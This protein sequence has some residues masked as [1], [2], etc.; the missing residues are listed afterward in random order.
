MNIYY[1]INEVPH[2]ENTILTVGTFDGVHLGHQKIIN[3]VLFR[4]V[5]NA[6]RNLL[7]TFEPHPHIVLRNSQ[8]VKLITTLDEKINY[9]R[10]HALQNLLVINFTKQFSQIGFKEFVKDFLVDKI[11]LSEIVIGYDHQ[12]GKN[13]E[14][15][16]KILTE[17][18]KEFDFRVTQVS[19]YSINDVVVSSSKIRR[20][21]ITGDIQRANSFLGKRFELSG[22]VFK[23]IRRGKEIG[24]PTANIGLNNRHKIIPKTG[25]YFVE[26]KL[27]E[28]NYFGMMNIGY[29]PTFNSASELTLEVHIFYFNEN[30]YEKDIS[31]RFIDR[32][33]DEKKFGSIEDLRNQLLMDKQTCFEK[34]NNIKVE[35]H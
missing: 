9:L 17:L 13:R 30:I 32:L 3:E 18:G 8:E 33:R 14:G 19:P 31:V 28:G 6:K 23:G 1:D 12:F 10:L 15:N 4:S 2:D 35:T 25:V 20:A 26:V 11:G 5:E 24:F 21:L 27:A 16:A 22:K 7:I 29:R 34:I